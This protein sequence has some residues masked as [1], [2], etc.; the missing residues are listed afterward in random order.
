MAHGIAKHN[1]EQPKALAATTSGGNG[2]GVGVGVG[3]GTMP[4]HAVSSIV[5]TNAES[6]NGFTCAWLIDFYCAPI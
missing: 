5:T 4:A 6:L 2:V 1:A 3:V